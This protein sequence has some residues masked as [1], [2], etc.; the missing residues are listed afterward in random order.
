MRFN[1]LEPPTI[2]DP[3]LPVTE[4]AVEIQC[5]TASDHKRPQVTSD[6]ATGL[7][8]NVPQPPTIKDPRLPVIELQG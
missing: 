5:T 7:K 6:R 4:L 2:K 3:R 1:V 8:F